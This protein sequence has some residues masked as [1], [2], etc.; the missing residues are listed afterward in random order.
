MRVLSLATGMLM[1]NSVL[2]ALGR[3]GEQPTT[4]QAASATAPAAANP[5]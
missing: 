4:P 2:G 3:S 1:V 5:R